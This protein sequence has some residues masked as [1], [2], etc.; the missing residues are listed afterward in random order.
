[1]AEASI[2]NLDKYRPKITVNPESSV[3]EFYLDLHIRNPLEPS[4]D[5]A[6]MITKA[7]AKVFFKVNDN[8]LLWGSI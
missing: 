1:M 4:M 7:V 3:L 6:L 5:A 2:S 8:F